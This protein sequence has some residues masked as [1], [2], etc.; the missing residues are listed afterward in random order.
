VRISGS[1]SYRYSVERVSWSQIR[2][3]PFALTYRKWG[4]GGRGEVGGGGRGRGGWGGGAAQK[5]RW[6]TKLDMC[7]CLV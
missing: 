5:P 6:V 3:W 4:E 1:T 2:E 7:P